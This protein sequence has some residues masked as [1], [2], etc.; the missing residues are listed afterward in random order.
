MALSLVACL[1]PETLA[2]GSV[3][4]NGVPGMTRRL[5]PPIYQDR[6]ESGGDVPVH[7]LVAP[8]ETFIE[9][10]GGYGLPEAAIMAW[11]HAAR[12]T[13]D[14]DQIRAGH[15]LSFTFAKG[16]GR[17]THC[18]YEIDGYSML[19]LRL[20]HGQIRAR[21][22]AMPR[23]AAVRGTMG[24]V[25]SSL[26]TSATS[27]G[28]P[29]K[30]L[31]QLADV[32]GWGID[33][34]S[35]ASAGDEFRL[36]YSEVRG[37]DGA[38]RPGELLAA[39]F[40]ARGRT[41]TA[42]R[43]EDEHG[44]PEYYDLDGRALGRPFLRYPVAF[45]RVSSGFTG[46][47]LHPVLKRRRP[48]RGIDFS[49]PS[50]TPVRAAAEGVVTFAGWNGQYGRQVGVKHEDPYETSYSHLRAMARGIRVGSTVRKGQ[51]IGYVGRTGMATGPH[52]HYMMFKNGHYMNPFSM[53]GLADEQLSGE[54]HARFARVRNEVTAR[55]AQLK[56]PIDLQ[57]V[58]LAPRSV[59]DLIRS[60]LASY[61][62]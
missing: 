45:R 36:L 3:R 40:S 1:V 62:N 19:S 52:L 21:L 5:D 24:R 46:S 43:F 15:A 8:E 9:I 13:Y 44:D 56:A 28:M 50:G 32:F 33:L 35:D 55:L 54:R 6:S 29:V 47:R 60:D 16:R 37:E 10:L 38:T 23:L 4:E 11:Y 26:A 34:E 22:K 53:G 17:L 49:A 48:H 14:L 27:V 58:A 30:V 39:E 25:Q 41:L 59:R 61:A 31:T 20:L 12:D 51:V 7:H 18:E 2:S 42:V 57:A